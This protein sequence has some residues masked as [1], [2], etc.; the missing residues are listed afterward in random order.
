MRA[1]KKIK[2]L[3]GG[4]ALLAAGMCAQPARAQ[5]WS[6]ASQL[7]NVLSPMLSGSG[8]Y[9]G[10][11]DV[12]GVAG[13]GNNKLNHVEI[14]TSQGYQYNSWFYMGAGLGIDVVRSSQDLDHP[15]AGELDPDYSYPGD[16]GRWSDGYQWGDNYYDYGRK[17]TGVMLP[18]FT[19]FRFTFGGGAPSATGVYIDLR[20]GATWLLGSRYIVLRDG[21][22]SNNANFYLRPS[23][24]V[25]VPINSQKPA[26]A[27]SFGLTYL[28]ITSGNNYWYTSNTPTLSA[29]GASVAFEW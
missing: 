29:L 8:A 5:Y 19:D 26:Q 23:V 28:L 22:L 21:W 15:A 9:K 27:V 11:V 3:A 12:T 18:L 17:R 24:G 2:V 14:S 25:R 6:A 13:V 4:I 1:N 16:G 20:V 10:F 7:Q